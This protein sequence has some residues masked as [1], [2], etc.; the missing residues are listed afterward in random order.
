MIARHFS[1]AS[2]YTIAIYANR[3]ETDVMQSLSVCMGSAWASLNLSVPDGQKSHSRVGKVR[4]AERFQ[5]GEGRARKR[6][7]SGRS[8]WKGD[9]SSGSTLRI[10]K[11]V[12]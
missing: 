11:A 9:N 1:R 4:R 2:D 3:K 6:S 5:S 10:V 8:G 7:S 12:L